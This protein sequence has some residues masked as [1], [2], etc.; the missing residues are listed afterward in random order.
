[1]YLSILHILPQD[2]TFKPTGLSFNSDGY[3]IKVSEHNHIEVIATENCL[4]PQVFQVLLK[5]KTNE[6][7][8]S[9]HIKGQ[10]ILFLKLPEAKLELQGTL[11]PHDLILSS[12]QFN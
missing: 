1:M 6:M 8:I 11:H 3:E 7:L 5:V 4:Y 12:K 9:S 2:L 10:K